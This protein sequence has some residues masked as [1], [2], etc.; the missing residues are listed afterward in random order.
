L[1]DE[2]LLD[3]NVL[4]TADR[5][6]E[7]VDQTGDHPGRRLRDR[8]VRL[9]RRDPSIDRGEQF[10]GERA[11]P[12]QR[13]RSLDPRRRFGDTDAQYL[14]GQ[15]RD[16]PRAAGGVQMPRLHL[17][18]HRVIQ[19]G[20][21]VAAGLQIAPEGEDLRRVRSRVVSSSSTASSRASSSASSS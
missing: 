17:T 13:L 2:E 7:C 3:R 20:E 19:D 11:P 6:R 8:A 12:T 14:P 1:L 16:R 4:L 5:V 15:H 9:R 18:D 21:P 10:A